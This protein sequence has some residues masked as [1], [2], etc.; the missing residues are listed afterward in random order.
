MRKNYCQIKSQIFVKAYQRGVKKKTKKK[1]HTRAKY[2][3]NIWVLFFHC[4]KCKRELLRANFDMLR[5]NFRL[6][7][8]AATEMM[9]PWQHISFLS[10]ML[11]FFFFSFF[12]PSTDEIQRLCQVFLTRC[13]VAI[14]RDCV[15]EVEL[16][17]L[18]PVYQREYSFSDA[19]LL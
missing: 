9:L 12:L 8:P 11:H 5:K 18:D 13:T 3:F 19:A 4:F 6:F 1:A 16:V 14:V 2:I 7:I 17:C 15:E 10:L